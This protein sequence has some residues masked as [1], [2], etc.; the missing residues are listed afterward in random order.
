MVNSI[1]YFDW[2][3]FIAAVQTGKSMGT[4]GISA[5]FIDNYPMN[6]MFIYEKRD[7]IE[8]VFDERLKPMIQQVPAIRKYWNGDENNLSKKRLK[9]I[10]M[11]MRVA[12]A[13]LKGDIA[14]HNAG[15]VIGD[16]Y[17]KWPK[18]D[19]SQV[20]AI[21]GRTQA[22]RMVG[23]KTKILLC[24][25]PD[26]DQDPSFVECHKP[27][28]YIFNPHYECP[29]C[30]HWQ[31]LIDRQI[32]EKP[33][34]K[35]EFDHNP[36]RIRTERAA[37]YECER[38][39]GNIEEEERLQMSFGVR[40]MEQKSKIPFDKV[41][42]NPIR[43]KR[44]VMQW[45][46]LVDVTWTF[47]DCLATF[48]EA[49]SSPNINDLKTYM[50][51]DMA[52]WVKLRAQKYSK[53]YIKSKCLNYFQYGEDA[54]VPDGVSILYAGVDT[55]DSGFYYVIRGFGANMESWLIRHGFITCDMNTDEFK[56]PMAVYERFRTE[57][58]RYPLKKKCG[59]MMHIEWAFIDRGGHRSTDVD[60]I[61]NH[62][63]NFFPYIGS[64]SKFSELVEYKDKSGLYFGNTEKLSIQVASDIKTN[65]WHVPIDV[66]D[67]YCE[68][69]LEQYYEEYTDSRGHRKK[70]FI[71]G[72]D[73]G[74]ADHYRD[75][76]NLIKGA[77]F[78]CMQERGISPS[79]FFIPEET[80]AME[81]ESGGAQEE[82]ESKMR[83]KKEDDMLGSYRK[84]MQSYG[85]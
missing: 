15:L 77:L 39:K 29:I 16:E 19:F 58:F 56:N 84:E 78:N 10:H 46:R 55:Q 5:Y 82:I 64:T 24:T 32:K 79:N 28:T 73:T 22:S 54:F 72:D 7:K 4:E 51:E 63:H 53:K 76:E 67:D 12:S 44:A 2:V 25:S 23:K 30:G 42:T 83:E 18:K 34:K 3:S 21:E 35:G 74:K 68:Q 43:W 47:S 27:N 80:N 8:E 66:T 50:N 13:G 37:Y 61:C 48:F 9:L 20:K 81:K 6:M 14:T 11:I 17:A 62:M 70:K 40:W 1:L 65:L 33:N 71:T 26:N 57:I 59:K 31:Y 38:C 36:E 41:I 45:N 85:W 49:Q 75:C 60:T 52:D 69:L